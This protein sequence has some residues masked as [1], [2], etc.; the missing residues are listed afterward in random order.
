[1]SDDRKEPGRSEDEE[2]ILSRFAANLRAIRHERGYSQEEVA[3]LANFSRSYYTEIETGKRNISVLNLV[4]IL[5]VL[6]VEASAL[7]DLPEE[8]RRNAL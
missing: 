6:E 5:G 8:R 2:E 7:I 4:K 1:M 3:H